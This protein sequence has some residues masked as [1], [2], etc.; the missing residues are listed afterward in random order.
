MLID[1]T[2][3][4]TPRMIKEAGGNEKKALTGHLGT[5]FDVMDKDFP[6]AYT[7]RTG[8]VFDV[9]NIRNRD[10]GLPDIDPDRVKKDMF[11]AFCTGFIEDEGYGSQGYFTQHPQLSDELIET[12]L[13]KKISVIGLDFAGI[14]RGKEHTPKDQYC[15]DRG[16]FIVEN[17]CNLATLVDAGEG[18]TVC[19]YPLHYAEMTGL[20]C[21]VIAKV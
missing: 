21:R 5:H 15:A 3:K 1:L 9:R 6:L 14:R 16:V 17:L 20:P 13:E 10:I 19:T 4:I 12:L 2:L 8:V 7:E 18:F 11:V